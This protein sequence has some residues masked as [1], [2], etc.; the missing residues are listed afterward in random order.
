M[1]YMLSRASECTSKY[2]Q[3]AQGKSRDAGRAS[4]GHVIASSKSQ[5][6]QFVMNAA[7]G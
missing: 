6:M 4:T 5:R 2:P 1:S 7:N 3:L